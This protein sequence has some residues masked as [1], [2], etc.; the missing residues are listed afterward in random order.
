M[1][2]PACCAIT[3][4]LLLSG[5]GKGEP[6]KDRPATGSA[7]TAVR[8]EPDAP[9]ASGPKQ[10]VSAALF[11][12]RVAPPP[13]LAKV[14]IGMP[15]DEARRT[16]PELFG[17]DDK[18]KVYV[19]SEALGWTD[20]T[21]GLHID[22]EKRTIKSL[23][24]NLPAA[25]RDAVI[26]AWGAGTNGVDA[27]GKPRLYW[28]DPAAGWRAHLEEGFGGWSL[29]FFRY[30]PVAQLLG[31]GPETLGFAPK[32]LL[33]LTL[34]EVRQ[35]Y[36]D[37]LV[38]RD[39]AKAAQDRKKLEGIAGEKVD[40]LDAAQPSAHLELPPTEWASFFTTIHWH[41]SDDGKVETIYFGLPFAA[42]PPA[43]GEILALLERK[44][45]KPRPIDDYGRK[46]L[47]FRKESPRVTAEEDAANHEWNVEMSAEEE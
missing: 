2:A 6:A 17:K 42:H 19:L 3:V 36:R 40:E 26:A 39:A 7:G 35:R 47:L 44:W 27:A 20:V 37:V 16:A 1:H 9:S 33:G 34:D 43:K 25:G 18:D 41:W 11:G 13:A 28:F 8:S 24:I 4:A 14:R 45:G 38:E 23:A 32:G 46:K 31:E 30:L 10:P 22:D 21:Y 29:F 15:V 5:C 12:A